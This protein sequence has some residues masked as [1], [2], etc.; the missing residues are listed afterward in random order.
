MERRHAWD[1]GEELAD[2]EW[3]GWFTAQLSSPH[4]VWRVTGVEDLIYQLRC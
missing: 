2:E 4:E 3:M 1:A